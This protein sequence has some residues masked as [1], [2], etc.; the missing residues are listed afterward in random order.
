MP[1]HPPHNMHNVL[2]HAGI[3]DKRMAGRLAPCCGV[4]GGGG[5][6]GEGAENA[7]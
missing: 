3:P 5:G 6:E 1:L 2:R 4:A 7:Y